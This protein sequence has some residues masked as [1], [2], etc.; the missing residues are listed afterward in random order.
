MP[1]IKSIVNPRSAEFIANTEKMQA[2][3]DDLYALIDQIKLGGGT[4]RQERHKS[5]GK[6]LV[7]E[8]IE[9][10]LDKGTPFLEIG[11]LAAHEV[12]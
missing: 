10:V 7:R 12:Y 2:Q 8:R 4:E 1:I 5:K 11:Q 6:L 3:V 9:G